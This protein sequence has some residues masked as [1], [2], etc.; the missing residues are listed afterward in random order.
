[1]PKTEQELLDKLAAAE[2]EV[3][4]S[5]HL[6]AEAKKRWTDAETKLISANVYRDNV[7]EELRL[8]RNTVPRH[9]PTRRDIEIEEFRKNNP[10][11]VE[12]ARLRDEEKVKGGR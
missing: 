1:M 6:L 10:E 12:L 3:T 5:K 8:H 9:E 7:R 4:E 11:V 2:T